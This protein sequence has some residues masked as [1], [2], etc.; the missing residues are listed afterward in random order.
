MT[1]PRYRRIAALGSS[2]ASG[3]GIGP[4]ENRPARRSARNYPHLLA[5]LLGAAL[6]DLTVAG[7]TTDTIVDTPQRTLRRTFP[8]QLDAL[9]SDADL[10]TITAGGNDLNYIGTMVRLACADRLAGNVITRPLGAL[11]SR[12]EVPSP[13]RNDVARASANLVRIVEAVRNRAP[14]ARVLLVDYLA[15]VGPETVTSREA[16]FSSAT[17]GELRRLGDAVSQAVSQAAARTDATLVPMRKLSA[18]H[19]LGA[20]EPWVTGMP[21]RF[22]GLSGAPF[23]PNLAGMRAVAKAIRHQLR[24]S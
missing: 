9:P 3:P 19:C 12:A 6:T 24:V 1:D 13:S 7:A 17:L 18:G 23:H 22:R 2:F 20:A 4:V 16:P 14:G 15:V 5:D 21:H 10:V 11:L 8:P